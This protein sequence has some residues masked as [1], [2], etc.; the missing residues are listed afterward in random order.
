[1]QKY[2]R[3]FPL[4]D[5]IS[6]RC[7]KSLITGTRK[8]LVRAA[9]KRTRSLFAFTAVQRSI[10][11]QRI[12]SSHRSPTQALVEMLIQHTLKPC[13]AWMARCEDVN[14]ALIYC[15]GLDSCIISLLL[16]L[17]IQHSLGSVSRIK[18]TMGITK[19]SMVL[20]YDSKTEH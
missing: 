4:P 6:F 2:I 16:L 9:F 11:E 1:M 13:V 19:N 18:V 17:A 5:L 7:N 15:I 14:S 3:T 8:K 20:F 12:R 10:I